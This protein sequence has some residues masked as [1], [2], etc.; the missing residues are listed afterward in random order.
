MKT[1]ENCGSNVY[2]LG[3]VNCDEVNYIEEQEYLTDLMVRDQEREDR[4]AQPPA[5]KGA[6]GE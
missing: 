4:A 2:G 5:G 1:C 3:C 6:S